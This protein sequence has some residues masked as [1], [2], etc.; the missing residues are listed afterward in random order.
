MAIQLNRRENLAVYAAGMMII[1]FVIFKW[2]V[3]PYLDMHKKWDR[4]IEAKKVTLAEM[5]ALKA[6]Y[7]NFKQVGDHSRGRLKKR[8]KDFTLFAFLNSTSDRVKIKDNLTYM[9]PS[10]IEKK[11][12]PFKIDVV[13]MKF[14]NI[15]LK[16]LSLYLHAVETSGNQVMIQRATISTTSGKNSLLDVTLLVQTFTDL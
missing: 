1:V 4:Q 10:T 14:S 5:Q 8:G 2:G 6:E 3:F 7:K 15:T 12:T 16:Q 9:K 11:G 13:E